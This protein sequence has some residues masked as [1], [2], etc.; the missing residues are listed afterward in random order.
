VSAAV[1][2]G[3][4]SRP[5]R[6]TGIALAAVLLTGVFA[7]LRFPYDRLADAITARLESDAGVHVEIGQ[8]S[9]RPQLAGPGLLAENVRK[10]EQVLGDIH[11]AHP[12]VDV[13]MLTGHGS[14]DAAIESVR[15]G[16]F[17]YVAK[18]CPLDELE[19]RIQRAL[20]RQAL[21]RGAAEARRPALRTA[22]GRRAG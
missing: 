2:A 7:Y 21:P 8:L 14:I 6:I 5:L 17:D 4:A 19:V 13:I 3:E 20:E 1:S 10:N 11:A 9:A 18:P 16:A 12:G 15:A 22:P